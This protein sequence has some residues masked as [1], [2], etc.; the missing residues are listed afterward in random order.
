MRL[1][2]QRKCFAFHQFWVFLFSAVFLAVFPTGS[3]AY[4][5][6]LFCAPQNPKIEP[7]IA[8]QIA[9]GEGQLHLV[10]VFFTDKGFIQPEQYRKRA[11]QWE[12]ELSPRVR[13][14]RAKCLPPGRIVDLHDLPLCQRYIDKLESLG[15]KIRHCSRW[16][17][18]VSLWAVGVQIRQLAELPFVRWVEEVKR[19][20]GIQPLQPSR[21]LPPSPKSSSGWFIQYGPSFW[22]LDQIGVLELHQQGYDGQGVRICLLDSGFDNLGHRAFSQMRIEGRIVGTW[23]FLDGD[24]DV[25]GDGHGTCTLSVVGG[26]RPGHL[27]G[28]AFGAEFLL[29]RTEDIGNETPVEEDTW[30][31]G[32][33]WAESQGADVVNS[34]L[35]YLDWDPGTG[36]G[37]TWEDLDG[38]HG[39]T[40]IAADIAVQKGVVVVNSAGNNGPDGSVNTPADGKRVIAVGAVGPSGLLADFS[41]RGPTYDG[42]IK[43]DV[44]AGGVG[45][46]SASASDSDGYRPVQGTSFSAPLVAGVCALLLQIHPDW[47]PKEVAEALRQT[48]TDLG[49]PGPDNLYGWGLVN[50][51]A[52]A[53]FDPDVIVPPT[54]ANRI[55]SCPNPCRDT[56]TK[57]YTLLPPEGEA[58]LQIFTATGLLVRSLTG[59]MLDG[60]KKFVFWDGKNQE[61]RAVASGVYFCQVRSGHFKAAGKI[62]L[63]K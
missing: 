42:R 6:R 62:A 4:G 1:R 5:G 39:K 35:G 18:G 54:L 61:G 31:A 45:V 10:W 36:K 48:A 38:S 2:A 14:R 59:F 16:L 47:T 13:S 50:A 40:T 29:A 32:L 21:E 30:I 49:P 24:E 53:R 26:F 52:A 7:K 60:D 34:S 19:S 57:I 46:I 55:Y 20:R 28:P 63:V 11:E 17:N 12:A 8:K 33:E 56:G 22:Q 43:P 44:V 9:E 3:R 15:V 27:V 23:D 25:S 51:A 41:S 37:Y 58:V